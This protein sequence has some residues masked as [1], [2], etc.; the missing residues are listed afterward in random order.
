M[1][2]KLYE[3]KF[4]IKINFN[5]VIADIWIEF[6]YLKIKRNINF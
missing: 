3:T 1:K 6:I 2:K 4:E 5:N